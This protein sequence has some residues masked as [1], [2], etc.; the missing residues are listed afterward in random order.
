MTDNVMYLPGI[1]SD[2][3]A[4]FMA[5]NLTKTDRGKGYWKINNNLL[6]NIEF[7]KEMNA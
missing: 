2:H 5:I 6:T 4:F 1:K 3:M 7:V